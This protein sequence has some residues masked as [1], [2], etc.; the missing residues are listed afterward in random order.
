M[1]APLSSSESDTVLPVQRTDGRVTVSA[2]LLESEERYLARIEIHNGNKK[3]IH[4]PKD[5]ILQDDAKVI[6]QALDADVLKSEVGRWAESEA[7]FTRYSWN[8]GA[9][10]Y[11]RPLR[12]YYG[13][14]RYRY[15]YIGP[16]IRDNWFEKQMEADRILRGAE[17]QIA[18]IDAEYLR[19]QEIPPGATVKG[20]M[21]FIK[22]HPSKKVTLSLRINKKLFQFDFASAKTR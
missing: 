10:S 17:R 2:E 11:Y 1:W 6:H 7:Y 3:S 9:R 20:F 16:Y 18:A 14:G 4:G 5:I 13:K 22:S 19:D 15:V 21:Q 8:F 12:V